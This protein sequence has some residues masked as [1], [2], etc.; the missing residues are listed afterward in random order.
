MTWIELQHAVAERGG[1]LL[2]DWTSLGWSDMDVWWTDESVSA[3]AHADGIVLSPF[4]RAWTA[5]ELQARM[6]NPAFDRWCR[7]RYFAEETG[8]ARLVRTTHW[9]CQ[10]AHMRRLAAQLRARHLRLE[11]VEVSTGLIDACPGQPPTVGNAARCSTDDGS[12][13]G[14]NGDRTPETLRRTPATQR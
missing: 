3:A 6:E 5:D 1:T 11:S 2:L 4:D 14:R 13:A 12:R 9:G 10:A 7:A 8:T